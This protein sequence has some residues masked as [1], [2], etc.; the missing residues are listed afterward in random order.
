MNNKKIITVNY[1]KASSNYFI[2]LYVTPICPYEI[3]SDS[4]SSLTF[5]Q[6][7]AF[8]KNELAWLYY[9]IFLL[10]IPKL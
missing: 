8:T 7:K 10:Q 2:K 5:A 1:S 9:P 6:S 3:H 4:S